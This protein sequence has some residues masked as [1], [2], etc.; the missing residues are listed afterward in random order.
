CWFVYVLRSLQ[1]DAE[2]PDLAPGLYRVQFFIAGGCSF[3][4]CHPRGEDAWRLLE[5][6]RVLRFASALVLPL[7]DIS[8]PA[9]KFGNRATLF[10]HVEAGQCL[11]NAQ[12][13]AAAARAAA[14][15]RGD[16]LSESVLVG[17]RP[18]L[19][20]PPSRKANWQVMPSLVVGDRP[21]DQEVALQRA[22]SWLKVGLASQ[23]PQSP[24]NP[25]SPAF[26]AGPVSVGTNQVYASGRAAEPQV[27]V[28][29][30]EAEAW[31]RLGWATLGACVQGELGDIPGA[32]DGRA[33]IAHTRQQYAR[34]NFPLQP[35][36]RD[37]HYLWRDG[38][39]V[40]TGAQVHLP[41]ECVHALDTLPPP[42][43][44]RACANSSTSGVAAWTDA[45]G[46]LCRA[47]LELIE[48]DAF[49]RLW[50][51]GISPA[52][53]I[54]QT[55]PESAL[56]RIRRLRALGLRVAIAQ[57]G[58]QVPVY[59]V[60]LQS[61]DRPFTAVTAAADF[62]PEVALAKALDEAEGRAAHSAAFPAKALP[63]ARQVQST[64]DGNRFY[65]TP[66]FYRQADFYA[67]G[68]AADR[69]GAPPRACRNWA[70]LQARL[71][72]DNM[73]LLAANLTPVGASLDQGRT[74]L[75]IVRAFI[76]GLIPIW[77]GY[78]LQPAG[79]SAFKAAQSRGPRRPRSNSALVHPFT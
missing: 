11:Q 56:A 13:M 54:E 60:F 57:V 71:A 35:F 40:H 70:Q 72:L 5:D 19:E 66:R 24:E 9:R 51:G 17:L 8:L 36:S 44:A 63:C 52:L 1:G 43:R 45:E 21:T 3:Q 59:S 42:F 26:F 79:L 38:V 49:L 20:T 64:A 34:P 28:R 68:T 29:R 61:R 65:Q 78:G 15:V 18:W 75:H 76:P 46:A 69:F 41:A 12:L 62:E 32:I 67:A 23:L 30:A 31:E 7:Y 37:S 55:L 6:P 27:A 16:T 14:T 77:F 22:E 2:A 4:F 73:E 10:A 74:P 48:R 50:V 58:L 47:T 25:V 33:L 53:V 39:Q